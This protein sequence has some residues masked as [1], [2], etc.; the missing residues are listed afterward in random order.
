MDAEYSGNGSMSRRTFMGGALATATRA[1]P[2]SAL[3]CT[4][5][6]ARVDADDEYDDLFRDLDQKILLGMRQFDVPGVAVG[7]IH[8]RKEYVR[9]YGVT[10]VS[11]P[12]PIDGNTVFRIAST[13]KTFTGTTAMCLADSGQLL[14]DAQVR[15]YITDFRAPQGA[16]E[17][18][19]RQLLN[20]SAGWLGY[21]YHDT[22]EDD[23]ALARYV[24]DVHRLPQLTPVGQ[25][26]SYN[27][28]ALSVAGRVIETIS[29][30]TFESSVRR[31][32]LDPLGMTRSGYTIE[33]SWKQNMAVPHSIGNGKAVPDTTLFFL[34]RS[35]RP[36]GGL[37][38]SVTDQLAYARFHLGDGRAVDGRRVMS[39][40]SLRAMRLH[41]GPGGT[42]LV[43][44]DGMGVSWMLRPTAEGVTVVQ[45]GGDLPGFHSGFLMVPEREFA[46][47][48]LT[49]SDS[50]PQLIAQLFYNDWAL[51]RFADVRNLPA[52][53]RTLNGAGL[54]PY[55]GQY[56]AQQIPFSGPADPIP[57]RLTGSNGRLE[58][59][60]GT[61]TN[62][63]T[64]IL[65]FYKDDYVL[66]DNIGLRANFLRDLN[67]SVSWF[68]LGGRL[69]RHLG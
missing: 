6:A 11:N 34:P 29:G 32:V 40:T 28:T 19:V 49:N 24:R 42:L 10:D 53:P 27:N 36:F 59:I 8:R 47:T 3:L 12:Q 69:F 31:L 41:P 64:R 44:L 52:V 37:F 50:G 67:G 17:V 15:S 61:G 45:H 30:T 4:P 54:A 22:G 38:S 18:T 60:E 13:S 33:E 21:D 68:R 63:T 65:T 48:M 56:I 57:V 7:I 35:C 14:F 1:A 46:I 51:S 39:K 20:H 5:P 26:F 62:S 58:M 25:T 16:E 2:V 23:G 66:V 9:G 55:E 43:E